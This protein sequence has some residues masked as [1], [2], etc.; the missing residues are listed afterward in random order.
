[1]KK[2]VIFCTLLGLC[3]MA[4]A[5]RPQLV[6]DP[7]M[8]REEGTWHLYCTGFGIQ[9]MTSTD[10]T[11]WTVDPQPVMSVIPQWTHDS[12][13]GFRHQ[14]GGIQ[15]PC[16]AANVAKQ[17]LFHKDRHRRRDERRMS[18]GGTASGADV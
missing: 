4:M 9:H 13:P 1:M 11:S 2:L 14:R 8:A 5:Q 3:V 6:H 16:L 15:L 10:G 12:V 17:Q 7:V 18:R